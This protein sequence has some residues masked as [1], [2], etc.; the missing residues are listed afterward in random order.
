MIPNVL[1]EELVSARNSN[2]GNCDNDSNDSDGSSNPD[3][4]S[5]FKLLQFSMKQ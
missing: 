5:D 4:H 2:D 1:I 3:K